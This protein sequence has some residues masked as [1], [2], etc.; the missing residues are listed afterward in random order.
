MFQ[1]ISTR[2]RRQK[3]GPH[4]LSPEQYLNVNPGEVGD[5]VLHTCIHNGPNAFF[6][7]MGI[8]Q[9]CTGV[10]CL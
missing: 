10:V 7:G 2:F 1:L 3:T 9:E 5:A 4:S 8:E 6:D